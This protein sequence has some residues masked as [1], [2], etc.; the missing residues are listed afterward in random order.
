[1]SKSKAGHRYGSMLGCRLWNRARA[2]TVSAEEGQP[3][4]VPDSASVHARAL[5]ALLEHVR[6]ADQATH[7]FSAFLTEHLVADD[8]PLELFLD[9]M[10]IIAG[11]LRC[12]SAESGSLHPRQGLLRLTYIRHF[13]T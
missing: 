4:G 9:V 2:A 12:V 6:G 10:S 11:G 3:G 5:K 7:V 1:M 8:A 13:P